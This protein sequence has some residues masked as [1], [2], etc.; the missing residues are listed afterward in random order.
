MAPVDDGSTGTHN[1]TLVLPAGSFDAR[2][3]AGHILRSGLHRFGMD[4]A[5]DDVRILTSGPFDWPVRS[6]TYQGA[7]LVGDAA[8]YY[9]P[10]T[11]QGIYQAMAGAEQLAEHL[12][13][14][15][16]A[17]AVSKASLAG[18]AQAHRKLRNAARRLQ[19][20]IEFVCARP[21]LADFAFARCARNHRAAREL[22]AATGDLIPAGSLFSPR[23]LMRLLA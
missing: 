1:I 9:D 11:G 10:F 12:D 22:L 8:G 13:T 4:V 21:A 15:L 17:G 7:V 20:I 19:H 14:A 18:Y 5:V 6:V 23:F 2:A 16:R 3:G